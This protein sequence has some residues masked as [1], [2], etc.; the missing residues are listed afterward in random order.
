MILL[1]ILA[2][3]STGAC[4]GLQEARD[5][6]EKQNYKLLLQ[7]LRPL[8]NKRVPEAMFYIGL[9]YD[10]GEGVIQDS[11]KAKEWYQRA[12][13]LGYAPAQT[14]LGWVFQMGTSTPLSDKEAAAWYFKAA[15]QGYAP[16]QYDVGLLFYAGRGGIP[17]DPREAAAWFHKAAEQGYAPAQKGLAELYQYG[18]GVLVSL[19]EAYKW[20]A[21]AADAGN[22]PARE[23]VLEV[24]KLMAPDMVKQGRAEVQQWLAQH[25]KSASFK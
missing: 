6:Y 7:E 20:F 2:S 10:N 15:N 12:A 25:K 17:K 13:I 21:L 23:K 11:T 4:A 14:N 16:A 1:V 19:T 9:L 5:A 24:E 18:Q 3:V 22:A 8:V